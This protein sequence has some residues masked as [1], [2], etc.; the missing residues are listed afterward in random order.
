MSLVLAWLWL[1]VLS[2]FSASRFS[3]WTDYVFVFWILERSS[4]WL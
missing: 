2:C 4:A 1:D 3:P